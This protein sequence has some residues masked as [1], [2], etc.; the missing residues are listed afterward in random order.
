VDLWQ[1]PRTDALLEQKIRSLN[2]VESWWYERLTSGAT[3]RHGS[4]WQT[5]IPCA[6]LFSDYIATAEKIGVRRPSATANRRIRTGT[7]LHH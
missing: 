1:I 6:T 3:A 2:S 7:S 5:E 4:H